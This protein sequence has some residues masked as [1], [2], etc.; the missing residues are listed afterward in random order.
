MKIPIESL[1]EVNFKHSVL[2]DITLCLK[3]QV[4][5]IDSILSNDPNISNKI[6]K[7]QIVGKQDPAVMEVLFSLLSNSSTRSLDIQY[8]NPL[9]WMEHIKKIGPCLRELII[10]YSESL[11]LCKTVVEYC[12]YLEKLILNPSF[13]VRSDS[14][15]L[16][17]IASNCPHLR[18]L[19]ITGHNYKTNAEA[20]ADLTAFAEKC[21]QLEELSLY[22][23]QLTDQSVIALAQ[24][25]S[26]LK[27]L[28]LS[29]CKLTAASLIALSERG[30]PLEELGISDIP[31]PSAE[32][33]AQCAHALFRI[34]ELDSKHYYYHIK[35]MVPMIQYMTGLRQLYLDGSE[36]HLLVLHLL[37]LL[38][39]QCCAGLEGLTIFSDSSITPQQLC[40]LEA[41]CPQL[42]TLYIN[43]ST[44][45]SD[46]VLVELARSCPH[47][48]VILDGSELTEV[49]VLALAAHC[50][51]LREIDIPY[52][53]V[54][55]ETVRQLAQHCR[56]LTKLTVRKKEGER[57]VGPYQ[58]YYSKEIRVLR[59]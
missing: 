7:L 19:F 31:F 26:R 51:Q 14:N 30:L 3:E 5:L 46:A 6:T 59:L 56:R 41:G 42:H 34:R 55:E 23:P 38:Q 54:T 10:N 29:G 18:F 8:S 28:K 45:T 25:C 44:C 4:S 17:S 50:R 40:E 35:S 9:R 21:P 47:L 1:C 57:M 15:I 36:D 49:G 58:Q 48:Q 43:Q 53:T 12:P 27:K 52:T 22:C 32:I 20:V 16:Q 11:K 37:L 13:Y 33:A 24:H 39:G 2:Y